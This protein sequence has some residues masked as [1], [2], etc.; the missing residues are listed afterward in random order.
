MN[1][2]FKLYLNENIK[3]FKKRSS[4]IFLILSVLSLFL[5]FGISNLN[6]NMSNMYVAQ[7]KNNEILQDQIS[8]LKEQLKKS[9]ESDKA[10]LTMQIEVYE[11]AIKKDIKLN[12]MYTNYESDLIYKLIEEKTT[13]NSIDKLNMIKEYEKQK[14]VVDEIQNIL[15][16]K[17]FNK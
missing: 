11:Y 7:D 4:H 1:K 6:K 5:A 8:G 15:D 12:A 17:D 13:L 2:F 16:N 10:N 3:L 9:N 14:L